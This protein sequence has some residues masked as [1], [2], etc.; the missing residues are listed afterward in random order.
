MFRSFNARV[1]AQIRRGEMPDLNGFDRAIQLVAIRSLPHY[2]R[3]G[4]MQGGLDI[5]RRQRPRRRRVKHLGIPA[6]DL[7]DRV[8]TAFD[9]IDPAAVIQVRTLALQLAGDVSATTKQGVRMEIAAGLEHGESYEEIG[10]RLEEFFEPERARVIA[11][12]ESTRAL[13]LGQ[14]ETWKE[15]GITKNKWLAS[16]DACPNCLFLADQVEKVGEPF[17]VKTSG[18]AAYRA[19][20]GPPAHPRCRCSLTPEFEE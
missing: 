8:S 20:T 18:P 5:S 7:A 6:G 2:W 10:V 4:V 12:T 11:H 16:A 15:Y 17:I 13:H 1:Q 14:Q 3:A 9:V 19:I